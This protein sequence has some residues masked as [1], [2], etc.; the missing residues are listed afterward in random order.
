[1][2]GKM[3]DHLSKTLAEIRDAGL[4]KEERII[5][6]AQQATIT[7]KGEEVLNFCD[8]SMVPRQ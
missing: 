7:V 4:Y 3:K 1:M 2:Y 8:S 5:E 6:S